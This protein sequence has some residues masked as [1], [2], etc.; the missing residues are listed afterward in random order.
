MVL[1]SV[2]RLFIMLPT[3]LSEYRLTNVSLSNSRKAIAIST[4]YIYNQDYGLVLI[5]YKSGGTYSLTSTLIDSFLGNFFVASLL[6][7]RVFTRNLLTGF[8]IPDLGY[9]L[10]RIRQHTTYETTATATSL[11]MV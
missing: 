1:E 3:H 8:L 7:L 5:L 4:A 2:I 9:E 11:Y 10:R 6:T